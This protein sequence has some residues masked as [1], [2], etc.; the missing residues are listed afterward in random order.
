MNVPDTDGRGLKDKVLQ[1]TS[2]VLLPFGVEMFHNMIEMITQKNFVEICRSLRPN[3]CQQKAP[4][5]IT[6]PLDP[7]NVGVKHLGLYHSLSVHHLLLGHL[8]RV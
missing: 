3:M 4:H 6:E 1:E 5:S 7:L 2:S 8:L